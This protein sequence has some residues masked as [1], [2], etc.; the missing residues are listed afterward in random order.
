MKNLVMYKFPNRVI[1]TNKEV[2]N[3]LRMS[4]VT[5]YRKRKSGDFPPDVKIGERIIGHLTSDVIKYLEMNYEG[6]T[7]K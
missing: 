5:C 7:F 4:Y 1:L 6:G 2:C 3:L